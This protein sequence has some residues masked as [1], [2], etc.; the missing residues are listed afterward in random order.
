MHADYIP[1]EKYLEICGE[2]NLI[3]E[4]LRNSL[5]GLLHDL[6]IVI[7]FP[8]DTQVL[9]PRWVTQGVYG[10]LTSAQLVKDRG[11]FYLADC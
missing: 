9:N 7:R 6:G 11:Q 8:G 1:V 2:E 10:L 5:L 4:D 3:D